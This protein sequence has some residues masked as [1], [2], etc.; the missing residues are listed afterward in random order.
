[1]KEQ[2]EITKL[3]FL[4]TVNDNFIV[5]RFFNV[6][7]YNSKAKNSVELMNLMDEFIQKMKHHLKIKTVTYMIDNQYEILENPEILETSFT[8]GPEVF[9]IYLKYNGN[10]MNHITFDAKCYPPKVRYTVDIRPYLKNILTN[11]TEVFSTK[12]LT[13]EYM[14]YSLV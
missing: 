4:V 1:M 7:D 2:N 14:G 3:E 11:L 6:K 5:Q 13:N 12:N 9:N 8:D 10:I